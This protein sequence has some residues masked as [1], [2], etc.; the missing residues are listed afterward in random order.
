VAVGPVE[1]RARVEA[2]LTRM[3]VI[4]SAGGAPEPLLVGVHGLDFAAIAGRVFVVS[5]Y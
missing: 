5:P 2:A 3:T 4:S 1:V